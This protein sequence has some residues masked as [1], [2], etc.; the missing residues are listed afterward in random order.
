MMLD[1]INKRLAAKQKEKE[2]QEK[3]AAEAKTSE[4]EPGSKVVAISVP[5]EMYDQLVEI[6][7]KHGVR[8]LRGAL[9]LAAKTGIRHLATDDEP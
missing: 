8:G 3:D 1:Q 9:M 2:A 7:F 6:S 4:P 5:P